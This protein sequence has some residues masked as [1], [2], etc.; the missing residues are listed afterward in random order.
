MKLRKQVVIGIEKFERQHL[1]S[2][3]QLQNT[4]V[5]TSTR[6]LLVHQ[7]LRDGNE[8]QLANHHYWISFFSSIRDSSL[9][10]LHHYIIRE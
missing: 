2:V 1:F 3:I 9:L 5:G 4:T 7:L 10:L 6:D 8:S